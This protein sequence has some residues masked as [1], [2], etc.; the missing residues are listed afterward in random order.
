MY[1][2]EMQC[3]PKYER[4]RKAAFGTTSYLRQRHS[5]KA[6]TQNHCAS[7]PSSPDSSPPVIIFAPPLAVRATG[8][9][10]GSPSGSVRTPFTRPGAS[11]LVL[12]TLAQHLLLF[13]GVPG[14]LRVHQRGVRAPKDD[15]R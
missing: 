7:S 9:S 4:I 5:R 14:R 1:E 3:E 10:T 13:W 11:G 8:D 6:A 12:S 2:A 15:T